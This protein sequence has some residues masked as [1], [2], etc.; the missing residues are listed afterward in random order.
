MAH[1][2]SVKEGRDCHELEKHALG[3]E[4]TPMAQCSFLAAFW[5]LS[6]GSFVSARAMHA[7]GGLTSD[8]VDKVTKDLAGKLQ[9]MVVLI[10]GTT[11]DA[12]K[13]YLDGS[14]LKE[15]QS[16]TTKNNWNFWRYQYKADMNNFVL[17]RAGAFL[18]KSDWQKGQSKGK[19]P[20]NANRCVVL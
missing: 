2:T 11:F 7:S 13:S 17:T 10:T 15:L 20:A 5:D 14:V 18:S 8:D 1:L 6:G 4:S 19:L 16:R 9:V 12:D 3:F